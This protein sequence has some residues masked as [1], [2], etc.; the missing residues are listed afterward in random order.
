MDVLSTLVPT[1]K[2]MKVATDVKKNKGTFVFE[3]GFSTDAGEKHTSFSI[4]V[5]ACF[6]PVS[7]DPIRPHPQAEAG[8]ALV[9][10]NTT[11]RRAVIQRR[12]D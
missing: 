5:I 12:R 1:D 7:M 10:S 6:D 3:R 11:H 8:S 4:K 9:T 2:M